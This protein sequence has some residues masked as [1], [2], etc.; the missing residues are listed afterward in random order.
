MYVIFDEEKEQRINN[1]NNDL[2]NTNFK[3]DS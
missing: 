2:N 3:L 1:F